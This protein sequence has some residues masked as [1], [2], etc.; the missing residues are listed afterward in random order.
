MQARIHPGVHGVGLV[1]F[2]SYLGLSIQ[3]S[4]GVT[5]MGYI[6]IL[7]RVL[8]LSSRIGGRRLGYNCRYRQLKSG[9]VFKYKSIF[10]RIPLTPGWQPLDGEW[11]LNELDL[12]ARAPRWMITLLVYPGRLK[13]EQT[14]LI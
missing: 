14:A 5:T 13:R 11:L 12:S 3:S 10:A 7:R 1:L 4:N 9:K 6:L 8:V 2:Q